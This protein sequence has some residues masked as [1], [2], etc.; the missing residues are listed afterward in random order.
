V[1]HLLNKKGS[2][3]ISFQD[4]REFRNLLPTVAEMIRQAD[5]QKYI[6]DISANLNLHLFQSKEQI[7]S[8]A[9]LLEDKNVGQIHSAMKAVVNR[10]DSFAKTKQANTIKEHMINQQLLEEERVVKQENMRLAKLQRAGV[11]LRTA[12][13]EQAA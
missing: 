6:T 7:Y 10:I 2:Q 9:R 11:H 1:I 3:T 13:V 8:S 4:E 12:V 5:E